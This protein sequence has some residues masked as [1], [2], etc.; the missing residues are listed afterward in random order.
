MEKNRI[1]EVNLGRAVREAVR[2]ILFEIKEK[3]IFQVISAP[4]AAS[5]PLVT[6]FNVLVTKETVFSST[7]LNI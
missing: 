4:K 5:P 1:T 2:E 6:Q 3:S 7:G